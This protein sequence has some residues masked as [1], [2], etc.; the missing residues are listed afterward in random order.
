MASVLISAAHKSSGKTILSI[1]ISEALNRRGMKV[2]TFKK[3]PD[4]ID[5]MW[6]S[7]ASQR[8]CYKP[9]FLDADRGRDRLHV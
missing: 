6:L 8:N 2:Q 3:G 1:G 5:P 9:R 4:Y 7:R